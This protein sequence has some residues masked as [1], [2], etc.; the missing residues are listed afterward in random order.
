MP[1]FGSPDAVG[2]DQSEWVQSRLF[3]GLLG[4]FE[5]IAARQPTLIVFE[6]LHWA[7]QATREAISFLVQS[8][9]DVPL[10]LLGT[11]RSDELHRRHP[12]LPWLAGLD[13]GGRVERIELVRFD[14]AQLAAMLAAILGSAPRDDLVDAVFDRSDGNPFFAEEL[15]AADRPGSHGPRLPPTLKE[16]LLAHIST[17]DDPAATVLAVAA[18]AGRRVSHDLLA[19][20]ADLS[21]ERLQDGLRAAVGGN[22]LVVEADATLERYAFRHALVQEVV[23]DELLPGERRKLHRAIAE[24]LVG[25]AGEP[26]HDRSG[27]LGRARPPLGA[28]PRR[29][30]G[31]RRV[32][33]IRRGGARLVR[34]RCRAP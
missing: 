33:P 8:L 10:V 28:R 25:V 4:L 14:R 22:L 9:R 21:D 1:A 23:Y 15:L 12:L 11:Y 27:S 3:E 7:D 29:S 30:P 6:D 19:Q 5:R 24:A 13:R 17:V 26:A 34:L 32:A 16:I 20:V 18:V 31:V 2:L